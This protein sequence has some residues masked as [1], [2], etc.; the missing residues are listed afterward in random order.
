M[1]YRVRINQ[2]HKVNFHTKKWLYAP[3]AADSKRVKPTL[4]LCGRS[5]ACHGVM[6]LKTDNR[7]KI[8]YNIHSTPKQSSVTGGG[9]KISN[10]P[11]NGMISAPVQLLTCS[12]TERISDK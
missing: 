7:E 3:L 1:L 6:K 2:L 10:V 9:G 11:D 4:R 12:G 5:I 8:L